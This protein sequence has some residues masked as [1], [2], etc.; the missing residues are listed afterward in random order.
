MGNIIK[1]SAILFFVGGIA[2]GMLAFYNSLTKPEIDKLK[3]RNEAEARQY[4]LKGLFKDEALAS[5]IYDEDELEIDG[6]KE[7]F[8]KVRETESDQIYKAFV[9][10]SK[11]QGFSGVVETMV[12][13]DT[14]FKI[15]T[16]KVLKHTETPGLGAEAQTIKYGESKPFFETWFGGKNSVKVVVEKDDSASKDKVQSLT[17]ATI[18]TRAVCRSI[19]K[20]AAAAKARMDELATPK[21][22]EVDPS[23]IIEVDI[24]ALLKADAEKRAREGSA[25]EVK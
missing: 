13:T 5:L 25:Q 7:K 15:N 24:E 2:A 16:I 9:F 8:W 18:T 10:L 20:Y 11:G 3:A 19:N 23:Q 14:A 17:G 12:G 4:V 21:T 22:I 6:K 1:L